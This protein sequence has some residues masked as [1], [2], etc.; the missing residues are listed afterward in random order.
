MNR[1][2]VNT[3]GTKEFVYSKEDI[4]TTQN[5]NKNDYPTNIEIYYFR[6]GG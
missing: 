2:R 6:G 1:E 5:G 4:L 3:G